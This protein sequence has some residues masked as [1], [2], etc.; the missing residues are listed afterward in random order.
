MS[1]GTNGIKSRGGYEK[2]KTVA[3][4]VSA[5][6]HHLLKQLALDDETNMQALLGAALDKYL[7]E[8]G[9]AV[10]PELLETGHRR[11]GRPPRQIGET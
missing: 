5:S 2:R 8:R 7:K 3:M 11:L 1:A 9:I 10:E 4:E 6:I